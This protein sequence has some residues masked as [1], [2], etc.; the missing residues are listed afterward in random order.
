MAY[1]NRQVGGSKRQ[2]QPPP[3]PLQPPPIIVQPPK[4]V[5]IGI[6]LAIFFGPLGLFYSSV[7][8]GV[9]MLVIG[10]ILNFFGAMAFGFGLLITIPITSIIC[11]I[12]SYV[13]VSNY[14]EKFLSGR[15]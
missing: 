4:S 1:E 2:S 3:A 8:G 11:A 13:A 9:V 15:M 5:A 6:I 7:L 12:W 10:G 14:N